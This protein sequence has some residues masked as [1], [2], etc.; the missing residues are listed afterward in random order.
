MADEVEQWSAVAGLGGLRT[1]V[2]NRFVATRA[3]IQ[4]VGP[5]SDPKAL[6]QYV[7]RF[8]DWLRADRGADFAGRELRRAVLLMVTADRR[9]HGLSEASDPAKIVNVV[10]AIY[11]NIA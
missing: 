1:L 4:V 7:R 9:G 5:P 2:I 3:A 8:L 6:E 10:D 11:R